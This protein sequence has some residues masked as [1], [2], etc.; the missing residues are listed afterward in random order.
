VE[1]REDFGRRLL[2]S[3]DARGYGASDDRRQ[4]AIQKAL[5]DL[6]D[7]AAARA[8]LAR[9]TWLRQA[10]GDGELSVLPETEPE[11]CVVD[12]LVRE[13]SAAL[14]LHNEDFH[15]DARLRLRIAIHHGVA[16]RAAN[17]FS[18]QGV[19][20]VSRLVD[21][22]PLRTA[23]QISGADLAVILSR[24]VF[25]DTV[26]QRHTSLRAADFRKVR[27]QNKEYNEDAWIRV[28]GAD[29]HALE[30]PEGDGQAPAD[31]A[32]DPEAVRAAPPDPGGPMVFTQIH[33]PVIANDPTFGIRNG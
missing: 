2:I 9:R 15:A 23:L 4:S 17:G 16:I 31:V 33:G 27:I 3:V 19:V 13:L 32:S 30:L 20:V 24:R 8:T 22:R 29:I 28:P 7:E 11:P 12:D 18:G 6:L 26:V 21:S 1:Q 14:T 5:L 10:A 25:L